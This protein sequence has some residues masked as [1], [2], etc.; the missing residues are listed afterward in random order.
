V[1]PTIHY[2]NIAMEPLPKNWESDKFLSSCA[3]V[4]TDDAKLVAVVSFMTEVHIPHAVR[5]ESFDT[6]EALAALIIERV[7]DDLQLE[8]RPVLIE[9]CK[10]ALEA[11]SGK[12]KKRKAKG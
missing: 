8:V 10:R 4:D 3:K 7:L 6:P 5:E 12:A 9:R 1:K 11:R 2:P